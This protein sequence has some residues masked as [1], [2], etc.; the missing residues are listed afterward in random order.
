MVCRILNRYPCPCASASSMICSLLLFHLWHNVRRHDAETRRRSKPPTTGWLTSSLQFSAPWQPRAV[1]D[2]WSRGRIL[3]S[4]LGKAQQKT[5][6][7]TPMRQV[8][9]V[10]RQDIA[11]GAWHCP[12]TTTSS[13]CLTSRKQPQKT[14]VT[15]IP[16][17]AGGDITGF[18]VAALRGFPEL[19]FGDVE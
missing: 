18:S 16:H 5:A 14:R 7:V 9:G 2:L 11:V 6:V 8:V 13:R 15:Y 10:T 17:L 4:I 12:E 19:L 3:G 1:C